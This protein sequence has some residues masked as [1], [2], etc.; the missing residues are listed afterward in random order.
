LR[1]G[2]C[3]AVPAD[4]VL[5]VEGLFCPIPIARSTERMASVAPGQVLE[6]R[7]TDPGV[8]IDVPAWCHS[9]GH[10]FLGYFRADPR[11]ICWVRRKGA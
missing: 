3:D 1:L 10:E 6:I 11:I 8:I 2:S 9:T 4:H 7:A 5:D